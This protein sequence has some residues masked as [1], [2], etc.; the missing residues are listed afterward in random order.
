[1]N[2]APERMLWGNDFPHVTEKTKPDEWA[3]LETI[4]RWFPD[5]HSRFLALE[6]NPE[7]V[8]GFS[9]ES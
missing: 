8:Y 5:E 7:D 9:R 6:K 4:D 1:M 2:Y 3:L